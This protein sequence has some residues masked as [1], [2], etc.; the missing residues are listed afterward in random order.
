[1]LYRKYI[2]V[3]SVTS[4]YELSLVLGILYIDGIENVSYIRH[5]GT[6][7]TVIITPGT[8]RSY[9]D[10]LDDVILCGFTDAKIKERWDKE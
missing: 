6:T 5:E 3:S 9:E 2:E 4:E 1:M 7:Y 10:A 8:G